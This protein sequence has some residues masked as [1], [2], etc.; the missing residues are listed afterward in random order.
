M[1]RICVG[2]VGAGFAAT[3]H[4]R[5]LREVHGHD[6]YV[7]GVVSNRRASAAR[8]AHV[9]GLPEVYGG[10]LEMLHDPEINVVDL[11]VP[12]YLHGPFAI[13]AAQSGKHVICEKPLTGYF[14]GPAAGT[15]EQ[16][17]PIIPRSSMLIEAVQNADDVLGAFERKGVLLMYAENWIYAPAIQKARRLIEVSGGSILRI[18]GEESH[19]GSHAPYA[20]W[21]AQSGG[22]SLFVKGSHPLGA[23][24]YLKACE[25][26]ARNG[27]PICP[28]TVTAEVRDLTEV[29]SFRAEKRKWITADLVDVE[30]WG[31][32]LVTFEDGSVA[33]I[34]ASD[35]VLGGVQNRLE[36]YL[37]NARINC[38]LSLNT[39]CTAFAPDGEIF[40][41][42]YL[43]E[44]VETK[45]GWSFPSPDEDWMFGYPQ[46]MQDFMECIAEGRE[47]ISGGAIARDVV[48]TIY[49]A[50]VSAEQ[51]ERV[52][53][54]LG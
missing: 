19:S 50:Y 4:M 34:T 49:S 29:A 47:P 9:H 46:E 37:S 25:G 15:E 32:M 44:K 51:G 40:G 36:I 39:A 33:A 18:D 8:F 43:C 27:A 54:P 6:V 38:N 21:W 53:I 45:A 11:C 5:A 35:A 26:R 10:F 31:T 12:N 23:A 24:L 2:M 42:E 1:A 14:G 3:L 22:G 28:K 13:Q 20:R 16:I 41:E 48:A 52:H 7:K 17:G 30:N